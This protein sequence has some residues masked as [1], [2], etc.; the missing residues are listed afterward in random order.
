MF[1]FDVS[2]DGKDTFRLTATSRDVSH[3][4]R[5]GKGRSLA[6]IQRDAR[7]SQLEEIAHLASVRHGHFSG[8]LDLFRDTCDIKPLDPDD[9]D[10]K[11]TDEGDD[12][13][14]DES[15]PTQPAP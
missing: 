15:G 1:L 3:W 13:D 2:P 7:M 4:E 10:V 11:G 9:P 12:G 14:P 5:T 8:S 6:A